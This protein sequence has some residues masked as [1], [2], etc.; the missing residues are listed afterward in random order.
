MAGVFF[1]ANGKFYAMGGR[2]S[3][4]AGSEFTH[5]LEYDPAPTVGLPSLP[6]ILT[7]T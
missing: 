6:L 7:T 3:D 4:T 1:P 2:M 5:P